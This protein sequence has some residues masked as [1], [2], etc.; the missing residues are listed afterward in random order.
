VKQQKTG[1]VLLIPVHRQLQ[2][3]LETIPR[4]A[5][6]IL[7]STEGK[8]WR[9]FQTAWQKHR[10]LAVK[11]RGLVFHGLRKSAVVTLLEA[12][13]TEAETAAVTGQTLTMVAHYAKQVTQKKLAEAAVLKWERSRSS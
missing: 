1:K 2:A 11:E 3:V 5:V 12:G 8:P 13:A 7:T 9:A 4:R 10:P 6:T